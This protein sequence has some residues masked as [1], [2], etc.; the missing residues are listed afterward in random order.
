M[1]NF[2]FTNLSS[3]K[4]RPA[5]IIATKGE[6]AIVI[7]I[8]SNVPDFLK[9]SWIVIEES[10]PYFK[11]MGLKKRSVIKTEK[12]ATIHNSVIKAKIGAISSEAM[13]EIKS[14]LIKTLALN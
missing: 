11:Q 9:D 6:D 3:Y 8:F 13:R 2:P 5:L 4:V 12:I 7:G 10:S 14:T 1:V